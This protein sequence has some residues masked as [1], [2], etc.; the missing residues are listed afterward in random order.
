M[1]SFTDNPQ[2]LST[3]N[4]YVAQLP[5]EAMVKVGMQKQKQYDEGI[6]KIQTNI[7]NIAGLDVGR[8]VDRAYLQSKI[9]QLGSDTR[10]FAMSDFS[11]AQLVNS[12]NGMT[13]SIVQDEYVKA[14]VSSTA[15]DRKQMTLIEDARSKGTLTPHAEYNYQLQRSKYYDNY[16][17][18]QEDGKAI[19]YSGRYNAS[20]DIDKN[21]TEAIKAIGDSKWSDDIIF[22]KDPTTGRLLLDESGKPKYSPY[23]T[24]MIKEGKFSENVSAAIEGVLN[25]P[26]ARQELSMR[27][28]YNYRGY[29]SIDDFTKMYQGEADKRIK[30]ING[31][32]D[33]LEGKL[34]S[35]P[36]GKEGDEI[37]TQA[38]QR[39]NQLN[40]EIT[41]IQN[42]TDLKINDANEFSSLD[43]Y[44]AAVETLKVKNNYLISG[45]TEKYQRQII[46]NIPYNSQQKKLEADRKWIM[47]MDSSKRGWANVA[48]S[49]RGAALNELKWAYDPTNPNKLPNPNSQDRT[50]DAAQAPLDIVAT[51]Y[52]EF[53]DNAAVLK[54]DK[55]NLVLQYSLKLEQSKNGG[56][57]KQEIEQ[58]IK[59]YQSKDNNYIDLKYEKIKNIVKS[60]PE[61]FTDLNVQLLKSLSSERQVVDDSQELNTYKKDASINSKDYDPNLIDKLSK[62]D[63]GTYQIEY[64]REGLFGGELFGVKAKATVTP[65][66]MA[67]LHVALQNTAG[68]GFG[69]FLSDEQNRL[70]EESEQKI[71]DKYGVRPTVLQSIL[72]GKGEM[73]TK[74]KKINRQTGA[75]L[76]DDSFRFSGRSAAG[77]YFEDSG[78]MR[79][80]VNNEKYANS[81][82]AM[83][84]AITDKNLANK[85][86]IYSVY[87]KDPKETE[88]KSTNDAVAEVI[89]SVSRAGG[90]PNLESFKKMFEKGGAPVILKD[91]SSNPGVPRFFLQIK[92]ADM[93]LSEPVEITGDD[94]LRIKPEINILSEGPSRI[95]KKFNL[96][97]NKT[98]NSLTDNIYDENA[99]VGAYI[100]E[101]TFKEKYKTN[102]VKGVDVVDSGRGTYNIC[103]YIKNSNDDLVPIIYPDPD[104]PQFPKDMITLDAAQDALNNLNP[105]MIPSIEKLAK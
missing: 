81:I 40:A 57:D 3:F 26:E 92:N 46:E 93:T 1:A 64:D 21:L 50:V 71:I 88:R 105:K 14:A 8:D 98:T 85:N 18:K 54:E 83:A 32:I 100:G 22:E 28:V 62:Q 68:R 44:K 104:N 103:F 95:V 47:D 94:A 102:K 73:G 16:N 35:S 51:K 12:V 33:D 43:G 76:N 7:D 34:L 101:P 82:N 23:A 13:N 5:V 30:G 31:D 90:A 36:K 72:T 58:A 11:N 69:L 39:I 9:N 2:A 89:T 99:Y 96:G 67:T 63:V 25:R 87:G 10:I 27:G 24:R 20:W 19:N 60:N 41:N 77:D 79:M 55:Y 59:N 45:V 56:R 38:Q 91:N 75:T 86:Y 97:N 48:I 4:P 70:A 29:D 52:K 84:K 42:G 37:R 17:L 53:E 80:S 15:N 49:E 6:Q 78:K 66:D 74:V 61:N 65:A